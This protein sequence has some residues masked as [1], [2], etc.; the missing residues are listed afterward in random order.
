MTDAMHSAIPSSQVTVSVYASAIKD[1]KIY[2]IASL[3]RITDGIFMMAYDFAT[4]ASDSAMPTAPLYGYK[5]G[6]YWYDV[7]TAVDDFLTQMPANK[8]ILGVPWYAYN[9]AVNSPGVKA[10]TLP[11]Y[12]WR[13]KPFTQ[14][15]GLTAS[16]ITQAS[17]DYQ[18][19]WDN[20]GQVGWK[21]Y[22]VPSTGTWRMV[23]IDDVKSLSLKYDFAKSKNLQGVGI[24]ALGFDDG[25]HEMWSLLE[26]EF[27]TKIANNAVAAKSS[28]PMN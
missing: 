12:S 14:T 6:T 24:W 26:N 25:T 2:D 7:S 28:N 23:F 16:Q 5:D 13:G 10:A 8:L 19:G 17:N 1:P 18:S 4:V 20:E 21:A 15:Y 27:G 22:Y 11:S 9:Y 3:G